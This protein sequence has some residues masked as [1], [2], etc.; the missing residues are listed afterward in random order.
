M[1]SKSLRLAITALTASLFASCGS[2]PWAG[3]A[4][5]NEVNLAF[6]VQNNL[7]F[8]TTVRIN[9]QPGRVFFGSADQRT[10][11]DPAFA[12]KAG[13]SGYTLD[14]NERE[15]VPITPVI[16]P[17]NGVGDVLVGADVW[18]GHAVTIDYR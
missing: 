3:E 9:N 11:I 12:A 17:L 4:P 10:V 8:L 14:M 16:T 18:D 13:R 15:S 5:A 1:L 7:L 6:T 2:L